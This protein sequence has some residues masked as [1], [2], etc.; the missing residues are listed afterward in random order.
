MD[1]LP[2]CEDTGYRYGV[3]GK[4][5]RTLVKKQLEFVIKN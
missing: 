4:Y 5:D 1:A 3:I 2:W